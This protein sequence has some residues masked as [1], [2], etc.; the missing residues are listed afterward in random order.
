M[1]HKEHIPVDEAMGRIKRIMEELP[2]VTGVYF[3][4][5]QE[6]LDKDGGPISHC[7]SIAHGVNPDDVFYAI[8]THALSSMG[9]DDTIG[10]VSRVLS[11]ALVWYADR[12]GVDINMG[13]LERML[14][15]ATGKAKKSAPGRAKK[16]SS[17]LPQHPQES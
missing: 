3:L 4:A 2:Y 17:D 16:K 8:L 10:L 15:D 12:S 11:R 5:T 7:S 14:R 13:E 1:E 6:E 9:Q